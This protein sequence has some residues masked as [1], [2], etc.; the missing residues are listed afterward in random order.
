MRS[1]CSLV[2]NRRFAAARLLVFSCASCCGAAASS[3]AQCARLSGVSSTNRPVARSLISSER[4]PVQG[5]KRPRHKAG[6]P[7]LAAPNRLGQQFTFAAPDQ[8]WV[9]GITY[10]RTHEGWLYLAVVIDLY[11]RAVIGWSM[12]STM[13]T[14]LALVQG[15]PAHPQ[16]EPPWQ[17]LRQRGG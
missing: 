2:E 14:E 12:K 7:A 5:Y 9:T 8:A 17:L 13:A 16:H 3:A 1:A 11:S 10:I 6:K 4:K 15:Q